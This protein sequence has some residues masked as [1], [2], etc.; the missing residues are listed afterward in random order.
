MIIENH[1]ENVSLLS[2]SAPLLIAL[3]MLL[4]DFSSL[5]AVTVTP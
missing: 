1:L 2:L 4:A 3:W 5:N